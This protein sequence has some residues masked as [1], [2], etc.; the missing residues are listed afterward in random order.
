MHI[1]ILS[2]GISERE[3]SLLSG[4][5]VKKAILHLGHDVKLMN[6][7]NEDVFSIKNLNTDLIFNALHG[8]IGENGIIQSF[9]EVKGL[10]YTGSGVLA[11]ALAMNKVFSKKIFKSVGISIAEGINGPVG[12][13][14]NSNSLKYPYIAKPI[15]GGSSVNINL[16][17]DDADKSNVIGLKDEVLI[18]PFIEG[19]EVSVAIFNGDVIGMIEIIYPEKLYDYAAKYS[20][21]NTKYIFPIDLNKNIQSLLY[22]NALKAHKSLGCKG[23]TRAD[24]RLDSNNN[25]SP[26]LLEINTLPGLTSHSLVPKI[27]KNAGIDFVKLIAMI[28]KDA[29]N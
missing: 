16:I 25:F 22:E 13:L 28:I 11:S 15:D 4:E 6:I 14:I 24:F 10:P 20:S 2:G 12:K 29:F 1:T 5:A 23:L 7:N 21:N 18:E 19:R 17:K 8:G 9:F 27:F 26:I 3:V